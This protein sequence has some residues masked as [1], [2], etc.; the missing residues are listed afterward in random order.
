MDVP[1]GLV[2]VQHAAGVVAR[3]AVAQAAPA[4]VQSLRVPPS[5]RSRC[6]TPPRFA[7]ATRPGGVARGTL[8][9]PRR[10]LRCCAAACG[11]TCP[12]NLV[13]RGR[14]VAACVAASGLPSSGAHARPET[15]SEIPTWRLW[16]GQETAALLRCLSPKS[17]PLRH[18]QLVL[19]RLVTL[20][21]D[22]PSHRRTS[23]VL[24]PSAGQREGLPSPCRDA[25]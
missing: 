4:G 21:P 20:N 13:V 14:G 8:T 5:G 11:H 19:L 7:V 22:R 25:S 6:C 1:D 9:R 12:T 18:L 10:L 17:V 15:S 3:R 23:Q 24:T 2:L 16:R